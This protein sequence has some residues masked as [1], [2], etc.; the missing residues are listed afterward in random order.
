M[1]TQTT[2]QP[3]PAQT[4]TSTDQYTPPAGL[5]QTTTP[6][7]GTGYKDAQGNMYVQSSPGVYSLL[8]VTSNPATPVAPTTQVQPTPATPSLA[9][10]PQPA[11][12]TQPAATQPASQPTQQSGN[13]G[14]YYYTKDAN[15]NVTYYDSN[16]NVL[17]TNPIGGDQY[18]TNPEATPNV[19]GRLVQLPSAPTEGGLSQTPQTT[20]QLNAQ[21]A[22]NAA[23]YESQLNDLNNQTDQ[24]FNDYQSKLNEIQNGTF[25]LTAS[26]QAI[27]DATKA[28]FD[29]LRAQQVIANQTYLQ[30]LQT[31]ESRT[32][33]LTGGVETAMGTIKN[34]IDQ[35]TAKLA[36]IDQQASL[37]L[38]QLQQGF[39][40]DNLKLIT[41]AYDAWQKYASDKENALKE[42]QD[43]QSQA[44]KDL[45]DFTY[46][47][48]QDNIANSIKTAQLQLQVGSFSLDTQKFDWQK[49]MDNVKN[50]I[51]QAN[52]GINERKQALAEA[53]FQL[54]KSVMTML[55][56]N[57]PKTMANGSPDP[58]SQQ[59]YLKQFPPIIQEKIKGI[60]DYT[61]DP[62]SL[63]TSAKQAQGGFTQSDLIAA[64]KMYDPTYDE[65][66]YAARQKFLT[67][68]QA[69]GQNSVIQAANTSIDHLSRLWDQAQ[70]LGNLPSGSLGPFTGTGNDINVWLKQGSQNQNLFQ[71]KQTALALAGEQARIYKN[72]TNSSAAPAK[73]EI[74]E[75]LQILTANLSPDN[76]KGI[77]QNGINL[78]TDR[79]T[80]ASENYQAVMGKTPPNILYPT[81]LGK[82]AKLQSE[83]FNIDTGSLNPSQ[84]SGVSNDSLIQSLS[85]GNSSTQ[86]TSDPTQ[87]FQLFQAL[88]PQTQ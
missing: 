63:T 15:G 50:Q 59:E 4:L 28:Q 65:K 5:S 10:A 74:A 60:A 88:T 45:R 19:N 38:A 76:A 29:Q 27:L 20:D 70:N 46:K 2:T 44:L 73:D 17:P 24:A 77:I 18:K 9:P 86:S 68:W 78:M 41:A 67:N 14:V 72:G 35:G 25:P 52:L 58:V 6:G 30:G 82:I 22:G 37:A 51:D 3:N 1:A 48:V 75:Q 39:Q 49:T 85:G 66:Q 81:A 23:T 40:Q 11:Q 83:G 79:L 56:N 80:S 62:K 47:S 31:F 43:S 13:T 71:F 54:Q 8:P 57:Q 42:I 84:F 53:Q 7:G 69:G 87:F 21:L 32:G 34:A 61:I 16:A 12:Q 36:A 64:A 55:S 33:E 26:Q